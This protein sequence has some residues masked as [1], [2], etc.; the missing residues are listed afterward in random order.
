MDGLS[1]NNT[2]HLKPG[3]V[4]RIRP[5]SIWN[6][7]TKQVHFPPLCKWAHKQLIVQFSEPFCREDRKTSGALII[8]SWRLRAGSDEHINLL[9]FFSLQEK[10]SD[11][12]SLE[13]CG[14]IDLTSV[15]WSLPIFCAVY[16]DSISNDWNI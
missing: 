5:E 4:I 11:P 6:P 1:I 16:P 10:D 13:E 3:L 15:P 14:G 8:R 7:L 12:I 2:L 9:S